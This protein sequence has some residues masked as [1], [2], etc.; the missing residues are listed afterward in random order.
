M[1][2]SFRAGLLGSAL[3]VGAF[4]SA[5]A[6]DHP[7]ANLPIPRSSLTDA[8]QARAIQL[9]NP[10]GSISTASQ[11][12]PSSSRTQPNRTVVS[13]VQAVGADKVDQRLAV[14]TL[15]QYEGNL[16]LNRLVDVNSGQ[17]IEEDRISGAG[18]P[19]A[20]VEGE[21]ARS[22][23]MADSRVQKLI[24][25]VQG[26]SVT[27]LLTNIS[28]PASPLFGKRVVNALINTPEGY[29]TEVP[30][31]SVNLTD[32]TVIVEPQ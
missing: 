11:L 31:I 12:H 15:Y 22:L 24:E 2:T 1:L 6:Q 21:Y 7:A 28:D 13:R 18:A 19:V 29:L 14:V 8:E 3:I 23:V 16:T 10:Q 9:A 4:A 26:A 20:N 30:R 32:A 5:S 27:L 25:N 17:V